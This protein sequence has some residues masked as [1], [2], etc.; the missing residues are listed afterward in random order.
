MTELLVLNFT[1]KVTPAV[2]L[3]TGGDISLVRPVVGAV[4]G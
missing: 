3:D 2:S 4:D 1:Q